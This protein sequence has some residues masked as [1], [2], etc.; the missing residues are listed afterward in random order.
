M[1]DTKPGATATLADWSWLHLLEDVHNF[2]KCQTLIPRQLAPNVFKTVAL[3]WRPQS[4]VV[5]IYQDWSKKLGDLIGD[6][7]I[8]DLKGW[9]GSPDPTEE[10]L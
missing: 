3:L 6:T 7:M 2:N 10:L 5:S 4:A 9:P 1:W 8:W